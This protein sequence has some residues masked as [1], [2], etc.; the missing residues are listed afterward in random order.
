MIRLDHMFCLVF[1]SKNTSIKWFFFMIKISD[2]MGQFW[3]KIA[4]S[5]TTG[6]K[7]GPGIRGVQLAK[8][9]WTATWQNQQNESAPSEDS[10]QPGHPPSLIRLLALRTKKA[11]VLSYPLS[12]QR[13]LW[14]DWADAQAD[15]SLCWARTHFVGF[16]VSWLTF[17]HRNSL[18]QEHP[19]YKAVHGCTKF[20]QLGSLTPVPTKLEI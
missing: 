1:D 11:G 6:H 5:K 20:I 17:F 4:K 13:R 15:L 10:D 2:E 7:H 19:K 12:A 16:V 3:R 18:N 9:T 14:S 8:D